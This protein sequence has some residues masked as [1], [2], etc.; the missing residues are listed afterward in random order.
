MYCAVM[1]YLLATGQQWTYAELNDMEIQA[2][3]CISRGYK[4]LEKVEK[5]S[6]YDVTYTCKERDD[7]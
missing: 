7:L 3:R 5:K 1:I 4:C 2:L 6:K